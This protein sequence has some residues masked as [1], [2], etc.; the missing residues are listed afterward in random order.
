[1]V[2]EVLY[3]ERLAYLEWVQGEWAD[4]AFTEEGR[5]SHRRADDKSGGLPAEESEKPYTAR[6]V[7]LSS[8]RLGLTAKIDV[9]EGEGEAVVPIE[10]KRGTPPDVPEGAHLPERAQLCVQVLL[11]REH[12]FRC[13][14]AALYFAAAR[15]RV[16]IAI[17]DA[18]VAATLDAA[19]KARALGERD[20]P[21]PPLIDSRKCDGCSLVGICLPDETNAMKAPGVEDEGPPP[22]AI[23][24]L[25]PA[26]DDRKA[27]YVHE[28][29]ARVGIEAE[30]LVIRGKDVKEEARLV[31]TSHVSLFGNVTLSAQA[32][33]T[34]A[35][36]GIPVMLFSYGGWFSARIMGL[37]G[38]N[39]ELRIA[40][41]R[42]ADDPRICLELARGFVASKIRN[43]RTMLR[44][45]HASPDSAL[46]KQLEAYAKDA[47]R[48]DA[49]P[50]LLGIEGSAARAYFGAFT[51]MFRASGME[52]SLDGRNRRPPRD[53]VNA[54]LSFCYSLLTKELVLACTAAGLDPLR[55]FY[56]QPRF[57]RPALA[58]DLME[59][60]RPLLG[61]SVVIGVLNN[62]VVDAGD[63]VR[64]REG[65]ALTAPA[66]KKVIHAFERRLDQEITHPVFGYAISWRRV[67]EVQARL[68]GRRLLGEIESYPSMRTR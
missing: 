28:Q 2:N 59:E 14:E 30:R 6:S 57:G 64:H 43:A 51:G 4:N 25:H 68:L 29:G 7:W 67:L 12:G 3:C 20:G 27:V 42:V 17:D 44:R 18:L 50:S 47:E 37:D 13:D 61:D 39:V 56:H 36:R 23:R 8:E 26:R 38:K 62:G 9:V 33:R 52:F 24:R 11:L 16:A 60:L 22:R 55:G 58:L 10:Y 35:E 48:A 46:L 19:A 45:N 40:Q 5:W 41:H 15:R 66:R 34:L 1:M 65:V 54:L 32:A 31:D 63:F 21:P 53:P 49:L